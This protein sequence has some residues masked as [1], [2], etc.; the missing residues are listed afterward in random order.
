MPAATPSTDPNGRRLVLFGAPLDAGASRRGAVMGPTALRIAGLVDELAALGHTVVDRGDLDRDGVDP[1][2]HGADQQL[3]AHNLDEIIGWVAPIRRASAEIL[4]AGDLPI[5]LGGDHSVAIGSVE[6]ARAHAEATGRELFVLWI[7]AHADFNTPATS[8]SGNVHGMALAALCGEEGLD[9]LYGPPARRPLAPERVHL[10]GVR[11]LD[12]GERR[13]LLDRGI[14]VVDMARIDE[15]GVAR[16]L[17]RILERVAAVDGVLH[18]GLDVDALDPAI[19]PG[20]GT[21]V[22][23][24]LTWREAHLVMEMLAESGRL[25][26]LDVVELNPFLDDQGRSAL[27]LV[28]LLGSLFGRRIIDRRPAAR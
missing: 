8:P 4:A 17:R 15:D 26:S 23:G 27:L 25:F 24:G 3:F 20:V 12:R 7:D 2:V 18:V 10:F 19:A 6:A 9:G 1:A 16:P 21:R 13:L 14:D 5:L 22:P 28:D 11:Q